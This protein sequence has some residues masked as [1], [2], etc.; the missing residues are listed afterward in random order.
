MQSE[1]STSICRTGGFDRHKKMSHI[2]RICK[3]I[4]SVEAV[5]II[6]KA[7]QIVCQGGV[8]V[9]ATDTGYLLG[10][11]GLNR[12]A[13]RRVYQIKGRSFHKP[14]HLVVSEL[15]MA[16]K[17]GNIDQQAE[18][19]FRQFLPGPLTIIVKK[20]AVVPDLL[21]SGLEGV[22]LRIPENTILLDLVT[23]AG[24]PITATSANRSGLATPFSIDEVL[25]E[26]GDAIEYVDLILD[27][28]ETQHAM[29]STIIDMTGT[30]PRILREGPITAEMLGD[31]I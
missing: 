2:P 5:S 19:V 25:T 22:G 17:L 20:K 8:V 15:E 28:G 9:C 26:L 24:V 6:H 7:S 18:K 4:D 29:P 1:I 10:V 16:Q 27:Q 12:D 23:D 31:Y 13:I 11:D 21:V 14:I 3:I 30:P